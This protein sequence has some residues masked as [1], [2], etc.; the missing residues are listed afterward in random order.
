MEQKVSRLKL[1][2]Q[3]GV[4]REVAKFPKHGFLD[5]TFDKWLHKATFW[6]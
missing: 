6:S 2:N 4:L 1:W 5:G 3:F